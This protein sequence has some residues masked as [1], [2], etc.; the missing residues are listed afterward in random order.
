MAMSFERN[1]ELNFRT[2]FALMLC[3]YVIK[4]L[5]MR[6]FLRKKRGEANLVS[7]F[8]LKYFENDQLHSF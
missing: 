8:Y 3:S 7:S 4:E 5:K 6:K 1:L 2:F